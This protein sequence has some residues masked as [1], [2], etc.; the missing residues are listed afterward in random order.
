MFFSRTAPGLLVTIISKIN[1]YF[2]VA[3]AWLFTS[4][5]VRHAPFV[6]E[7]FRF[8]IIKPILK[9]KHG[10]QTN[11]DMYRGITL[12]PPIS[13]LFEAVLLSIYGIPE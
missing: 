10:D 2:L 3:V 9:N 1:T 11:L 8:G 4:A 6:P 7:S 5:M 12:T 13:K